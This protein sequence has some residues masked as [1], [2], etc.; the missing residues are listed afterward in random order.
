MV[1]V[2]RSKRCQRCKR[3]KVKCDEKWPTCSPCLRAKVQCSGPPAVFTKFFN[4][5]PRAAAKTGNGSEV[6]VRSWTASSAIA[7][8]ENIHS[9][10][11][12]GGSS[13]NHLRIHCEPKRNLTSPADRVAARLVRHLGDDG[14]PWDLLAQSGYT[15]HLPVRLSRSAALRD[16]AAL[17]TSAWNNYKRDLPADL[18]LDPVL[19]GRALHSLQRAINDQ[20][21]QLSCETLAAVTILERLELLFDT[22][23]SQLGT[24]HVAGMLTLMVKRGPPKLEDHLDFHLALE[25]HA[26]L[27][28]YWIREGGENF[29]QTAPWRRAM[30]H[31]V[32]MVMGSVPDEKIDNYAI[33]YYYGFWPGLVQDL[34]LILI[35]PDIDSQRAQAAA[36]L[37]RALDLEVR[38]KE[39]GEPLVEKHFRNEFIVEQPDPDSPIGTKLEF[40]TLDTMSVFLSCVGMRIIINR[41]IY[42]TKA[43]LGEEDITLEEENREACIQIWMVVPFIR[44]L[45]WVASMQFLTPLLL[46][47]EPAN[48]VEQEYLLDFVLRVLAYKQRYPDRKSLSFHMLNM[49]RAMTGRNLFD[50]DVAGSPANEGEQQEFRE[51]STSE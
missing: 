18:V 24:R 13:F 43:L 37:D 21:Q 38:I 10:D 20:D 29:F 36:F 49:A 16:C 7:T 9:V 23:R 44:N 25:N 6:A 19:Y 2:A 1:G 35:N 39:T 11:M 5:G 40:K 47:Y 31:M 51:T 41:M 15:R 17:M 28:F 42:H 26:S 50:T 32:S 30:E 4:Q 34:R 27:I 46:S 45:G 3:I 12:P 8:L 33:G 48:E 14:A 22:R